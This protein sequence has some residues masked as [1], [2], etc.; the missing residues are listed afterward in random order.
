M[1][2]R[3]MVCVKVVIL[4]NSPAFL[5]GMRHGEYAMGISHVFGNKPG[6]KGHGDKVSLLMIVDLP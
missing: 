6:V 4:A 3:I 5:M 1:G 2:I